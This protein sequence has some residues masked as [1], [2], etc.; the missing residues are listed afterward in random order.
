MNS[1]L[2][3]CVMGVLMHLEKYEQKDIYF[4]FWGRSNW[5]MKERLSVYRSTVELA[6]IMHKLVGLV[7]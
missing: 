5:I 3:L 2:A 1:E 4:W 7:P 6:W